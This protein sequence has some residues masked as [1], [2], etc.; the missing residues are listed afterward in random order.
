MPWRLI[1]NWAKLH[2]HHL[3]RSTVGPLHFDT[4]VEERGKQ[5]SSGLR[6]RTAAATKYTMYNVWTTT[7]YKILQ[8]EIYELAINLNLKLIQEADFFFKLKKNKLEQT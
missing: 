3:D 4:L 6:S 7:N 1:N 8:Q 5:G 2:R